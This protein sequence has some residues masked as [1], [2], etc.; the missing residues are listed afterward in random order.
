VHPEAHPAADAAGVERHLAH[1]FPTL[2]VQAHAARLGMWLFL[3]TELLLF[4]GLFCAYGVYRF[5]YPA[6]FK[7]ASTLIETHWG[8]INT[9]VLITSS[10]TVA[11]AHHEVEHNRNGRRAAMLLFASVLAGV[12]FLGI[13][14]V[15]YGHHIHEGHLPGR[16]YAYE[17]L[18]APGAPM[19]WTLYFLMTGLHGL[20]V[21]IGMGVLAV[22]GWL[23]L[24]GRY[25]T[26]Y[27]TPVELG[28]LY[29]HLVD[30]IWIFLFPLF[31]LI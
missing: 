17:G 7:L 19:F 13:K 3:A 28:G 9:V 16:F 11:L 31:Y 27:A 20:H 4:G 18:Q 24:R 15:E 30:L 14:S 12:I 10:L 8:A 21:V 5:L 29:W 23:C 26:G 22:I 1:H 25:D 2:E 6:T